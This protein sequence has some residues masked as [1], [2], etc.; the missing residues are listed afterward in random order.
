ML[1]IKIQ[2]RNGIIRLRLCR[3]FF[4]RNRPA[5]FIEFNDAEA[6]RIVDVITEYRGPFRVG[7]SLL[8]MAGQTCAVENIIA[9]NHGARFPIDKFF[10]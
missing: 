6:F 10:P 7:R 1:I 4:N 5:M 2:P 8:Q 3:F 9:Q